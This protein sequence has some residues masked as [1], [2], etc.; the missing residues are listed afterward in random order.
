MEEETD[1]MQFLCLK[2]AYLFIDNCEYV[3]PVVGRYSE[4]TYL[5]LGKR[6]ELQPIHHHVINFQQLQHLIKI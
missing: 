6:L 1:Y 4:E 2:P 3:L 5:G